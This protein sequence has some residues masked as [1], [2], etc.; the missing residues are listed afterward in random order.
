[1]WLID[2]L[3]QQ[4]PP[5]GETGVAPAGTTQGLPPPLPLV[6][7]REVDPEIGE[8]VRLLEKIGP[9]ISPELMT[10][11][12]T[13]RLGDHH[14]RHTTLFQYLLQQ[15]GAPPGMDPLEMVVVAE[16]LP[17]GAG[18]DRPVHVMGQGRQPQGRIGPRIQPQEPGQGIL[19]VEGILGDR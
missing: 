1:M 11:H 6:V 5:R 19:R 10:F 8:A 13:T 18:S 15:T 14:R 4:S 12:Q 7:E 16:I 17:A 9:R 3:H 2:P